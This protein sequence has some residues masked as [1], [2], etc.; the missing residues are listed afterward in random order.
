[1]TILINETHH[2]FGSRKFSNYQIWNLTPFRNQKP[3]SILQ[4]VF[5]YTH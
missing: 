3:Y 4:N 2:I 1:M 5:R